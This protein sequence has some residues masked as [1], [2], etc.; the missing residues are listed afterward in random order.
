[1]NVNRVVCQNVMGK[2]LLEHAKKVY[3]FLDEIFEQKN[4]RRV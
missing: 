1:M 2:G 3:E 4:A